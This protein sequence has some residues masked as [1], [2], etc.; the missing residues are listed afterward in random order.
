MQRQTKATPTRRR[1]PQQIDLFVGEPQKTIGDKPVWSA[2][3]R[4]IQTALTDLM[5]RLILEH[6]DKNR[7]GSVGEAGD[8]L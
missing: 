7:I 1:T 4:E 8:D 6:A 3:P 2:L 5:T